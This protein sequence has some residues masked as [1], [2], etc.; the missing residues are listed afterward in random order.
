V[1]ACPLSPLPLPGYWGSLGI[2]VGKARCPLVPSFQR[3]NVP[4]K[5]GSHARELEVNRGRGRTAVGG[6]EGNTV[7]VCALSCP[8]PPPTATK[9]AHVIYSN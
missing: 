1:C 9:H 6:G 5:E 3:D 8:V 7:C 4:L 2:G